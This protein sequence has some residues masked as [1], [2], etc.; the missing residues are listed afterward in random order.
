MHKF[1]LNKIKQ[2]KGISQGVT[3]GLNFYE[4]ISLINYI[5][6]L[7][8]DLRC[9]AHPDGETFSDADQLLQHQQKEKCF[10]FIPDDY[11][12]LYRNPQ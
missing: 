7:Q 4:T 8:I 3:L 6:Q 5:R 1:D 10:L 12:K 11:E 9:F 2:E